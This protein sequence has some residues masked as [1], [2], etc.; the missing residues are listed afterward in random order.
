MRLA[1]AAGRNNPTAVVVRS[2]ASRYGREMRLL[3]ALAFAAL[4]L[5]PT[6]AAADDSKRECAAA[7]VDA[8]VARKAGHLLDARAKLIACSDRRCPAALRRDCQPWLVEVDTAIPSLA[9]RVVD[10][11]GAPVSDAR[12]TLDGSPIDESVGVDPGDRVLRVE[13]DGMK[14][15]ESRVRLT[16]GEGRRK[17]V[18]R[19]EGAAQAPPLPSPAAPEPAPPT[20][21]SGVPFVLGAIGLVG[22][23]A[24]AVLGSLGSGKKGDLDASGCKP[25][26]APDEVSSVKTLYVAADVSLGVGAASLVAA[27]V[28]LVVEL[29]GRKPAGPAARFLPAP[30]GG[31]FAFRF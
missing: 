24:F 7:Y 27:G 10:A 4:A 28:V 30:G 31:A 12:I 26:C 3:L 25:S 2:R 20:G 17:V 13:A 5:T 6:P 23:G 15:T 9:V 14:P 22:V 21:V 19:L 16:A 29:A 18:V 1:V 8:Q 11:T